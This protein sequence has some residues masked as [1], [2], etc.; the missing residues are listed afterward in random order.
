MIPPSHHGTFA[1]LNRL[2]FFPGDPARVSDGALEVSADRV[3]LRWAY[4]GKPQHGTI[5][6]SG[7]PSSCKGV[8]TDTFHA[9]DGLV[10][11]GRRDGATVTL[12]GTYPAGEGKPDWGWRVVLDGSVPD[13]FLV[14]MFNVKPDDR[15]SIAV[16]LAGVRV[17]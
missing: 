4:E 13:A 15:E 8:F 9:A 1:G 12:Y 5:A 16:D 17:A 10:L 11:H 7:P 2:W 14:R 6:L 3:A